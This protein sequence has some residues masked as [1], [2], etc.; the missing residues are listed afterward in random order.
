MSGTLRK[1]GVIAIRFGQQLAVRVFGRQLGKQLPSKVVTAGRVIVR[2][3]TIRPKGIISRQI[4]RAMRLQGMTAARAASMG[5]WRNGQHRPG[6]ERQ[7]LGFL[8]LHHQRHNQGVVER[9]RDLFGNNFRYNP[10]AKQDTFPNGLDG[11]EIGSNIAVGCHAAVYEARLAKP[12]R[13]RSRG[14]YDLLEEGGGRDRQKLFPLA[15][16]LMFN[17]DF[18]M[19]ETYLWN[20]MSAE[21]VPMIS[22]QRIP[23]GY[24]RSFRPLPKSHPNVVKIHTAFVDSM[25]LLR[26]AELLYPEAL[27]NPDFYE[28]G[29]PEPKTLFLV[30][31]RYRM[32]LRE[33]MLTC[34]R[35]Y[36]NSRVMF[37]Q[38][39]EAMVYLFEHQVSHRDLKSDNILVDFNVEDEAPHLVVSDFGCCLST[40]TFRVR[41]PHDNIDLGGNLAMR[42]PEIRLA[43]PGPDVVVDFS[44]SDLWAAATLGYEMFTRE[45]P[46]YSKLKSYEYSES[47]L[48]DLPKRVPGVIKMLI[49]RILR[50]NPNERPDPR[51][52]ADVV[53]LSLFRFGENV[54]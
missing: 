18:S 2:A 35:N 40:G 49:S 47:D 25:P 4:W 23:K 29:L 32:T 20:D 11:Y 30:M 31:K 50:I 33:Y 27:P 10:A 17:Y 24:I 19:P 22:N 52:A 45:N 3:R 37:G 48:P 15:V 5:L 26:G 39:L 21:L 14:F 36:W 51:T 54:G 44:K 28:C 13:Q 38:L 41:Y 12:F 53:A 34:K 8:G 6:R 7:A 9:I 46:F 43:R 42:P 1:L 16:K